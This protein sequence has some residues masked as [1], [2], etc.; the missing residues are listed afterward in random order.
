M[1]FLV[2]YKADYANKEPHV[3]LLSKNVI[4]KYNQGIS[5]SRK[6][7]YT[8]DGRR[9]LMFKHCS[10]SLEMTLIHPKSQHLISTKNIFLNTL[11]NLAHGIILYH[12][13]G[14]SHMISSLLIDKRLCIHK[15]QYLP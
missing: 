4:Q 15:V 10:P 13:A 9:N 1:H 6:V 5:S 3:S 2:I 11:T 12:I 8:F 7:F 14:L